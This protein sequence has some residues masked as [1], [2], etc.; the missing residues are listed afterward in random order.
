MTVSPSS[1]MSA[2]ASSEWWSV[3][4]MESRVWD[5]SRERITRAASNGIRTRARLR[6]EREENGSW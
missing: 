1:V 4:I 5:A 2:I 3:A 6:R